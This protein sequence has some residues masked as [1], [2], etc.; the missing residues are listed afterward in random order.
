M[1]KILQGKRII[2]G[3]SGGIAAYKSAA[4]TSKLVQAGALV[5]VVLTAGAR[6][7]ITPLTFQA[8]THRPVYVD[9]FDIPSGDNIPHVTLAAEADL[10][11]IAPATA[12]TLAKL[13]HGLA[14]NLLTAIALATTAPTLI[15]PAMESHM[16]AHPATQANL[17][18]LV[19]WGATTIGPAEGRLASSATGAGR[20]VEPET[21]VDAARQLLAKTGDMAGKRV[22]VTAGGTREALDPVRYLTN[23]SSGKMGY[24]LAEAARDRGA[25]VTLISTANLPLPLGV[26]L[27]AVN[28]AAEMEQ[29]VLSAIDEADALVMAAAV[30]DYRPTQQAEHKIKKSDGDLAVP[31]ARTGD[32]LQAV[33]AQRTQTGRPKRVIG[34]AAETEDLLVN[35]AGKLARK[36]LDLIVANDVSAADAGFEVDTNRVTLLGADG[37]VTQL[38]LLSKFEVADCIWDRVLIL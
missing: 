30:A 14:D 33:A 31:L 24:A 9:M 21:I 8:L 38:P 17:A 10:L 36:G 12:N 23:R 28:S 32:I 2:L 11:L 18:Q 16:W 35:A 19:D 7:F 34:F 15:A 22:V 20:M 27:V 13:A 3:V 1:I 29:A 37:S 5:D 25:D 26:S 4:L 6:E